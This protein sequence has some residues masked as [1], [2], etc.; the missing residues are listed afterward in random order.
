MGG[1]T[2]E[3]AQ[4]GVKQK[5]RGVDLAVLETASLTRRFVMKILERSS[6]HFSR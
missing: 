4:E 1:T 6:I 2:E 5:R 3:E